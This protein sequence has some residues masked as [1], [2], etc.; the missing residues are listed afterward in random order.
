MLLLTIGGFYDV[1]LLV[2]VRSVS[3]FDFFHLQLPIGPRVL[4]WLKM[5]FYIKII[6]YLGLF[7][8]LSYGQIINIGMYQTFIFICSF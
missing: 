6:I 5:E 2:S 4:F 3:N 1:M 8:S 7:I